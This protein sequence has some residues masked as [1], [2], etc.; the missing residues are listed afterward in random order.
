MYDKG[1]QL[2]GLSMQGTLAQQKSRPA[3]ELEANVDYLRSKVEQLRATVDTVLG[4]L[5]PVLEPEC[6]VGAQACEDIPRAQSAHTQELSSL[7][8][9]LEGSINLLQSALQRLVI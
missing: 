1:M 7:T 5:G 8:A 9:Q 6:P 3:T 4:R 2:G